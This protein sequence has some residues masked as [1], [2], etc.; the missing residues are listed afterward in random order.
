MSNKDKKARRAALRD[1]L[2]AIPGGIERVSASLGWLVVLAALALAALIL[3][4]AFGRPDHAPPPEPMAAQ[5]NPEATLYVRDLGRLAD[6][7]HTFDLVYELVVRNHEGHPVALAPTLQRLLIGDPPPERDVVDLGDAPGASG[8]ASGGWHQVAFAQR[9]D[10]AQAAAIRLGP[11]RWRALRAHYRIQAR[12]DQFADLA[13]GYTL[14]REP[15]GWF[16]HPPPGED[17]AH[18]EPVQLGA[19][20]RAHCPLGVKVHMGEVR[21]LCGS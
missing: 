12:P 4:F 20:L 18:D 17:Q 8:P 9:A 21:S 14:W 5:D 16:G 2:L 11:G 15:R 19:V 7:R 10:R 6:G 13:I 1:F 3:H